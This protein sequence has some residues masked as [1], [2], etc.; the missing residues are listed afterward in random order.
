M[1]RLERPYKCQE[2]NCK[3]LLGFTYAG[4][5]LHHNREVHK[6]E[7]RHQTLIVLSVLKLQLRFQLKCHDRDALI[8]AKIH[9]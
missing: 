1:D 2:S 9:D 5:L 7:S 6:K 3:C 8:E 4:G